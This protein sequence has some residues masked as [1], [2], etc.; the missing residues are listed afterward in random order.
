L[1]LSGAITIGTDPELH[2]LKDAGARAADVLNLAV[3]ANGVQATGRWMAFA[4]DDGR[5]DKAIYDTRADAIRHAKVPCHFEQ[6]RPA[7]YSADEMA[8]TLQ[9]ARAYFASAG[10]AAADV[11]API[12]PVRR[13]DA[14]RKH[15]QL[16]ASARRRRNRR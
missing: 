10:P 11:P 4:L 6:L 8:L 12:M 14:A 15:I 5:S 9:Y 16:T 2:Q 3:I 1:D 13:E 7:G